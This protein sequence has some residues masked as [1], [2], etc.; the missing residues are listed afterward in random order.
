MQ[1][2]L[3]LK[4][5]RLFPDSEC[6]PSI[7]TNVSQ[8]LFT[9]GTICKQMENGFSTF[10]LKPF[11]YKNSS[12]LGSLI[13]F[14]QQKK[15]GRWL[16]L[17][18]SMSPPWLVQVHVV[19]FASNQKCSVSAVAKKIWQV[20]TVSK[21]SWITYKCKQI[22]YI[23]SG[24]FRNLEREGSATGAQSPPENFWVATPTVHLKRLHTYV[25]NYRLVAS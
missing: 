2:K 13:S 5:S 19:Y 20:H 11:Y 22:I 7:S 6:T 21:F 3:Y 8:L 25:H 4:T 1:S 15:S 17:L 24:R 16:V 9:R 14:L 12:F 18:S 10:K 23:S